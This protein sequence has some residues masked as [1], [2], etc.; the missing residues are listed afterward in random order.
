MLC[1]PRGQGEREVAQG[2]GGDGRNYGSGDA[3]GQ[4]V[5]DHGLAKVVVQI[6]G[7]YRGMGAQEQAGA[8]EQPAG[9]FRTGQ[10][11]AP[12]AADPGAHDVTLPQGVPFYPV[13][14]L[15]SDGDTAVGD[16]PV[17]LNALRSDHPDS[18]GSTV[19]GAVAAATWSATV[20]AW[21]CT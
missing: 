20:M 8:A 21:D 17:V 3:L 1:L 18:V 14:C 12:T 11:V 19:G 6:P 13:R 2:S 15:G 5:L 16:D 7:E 10:G 9:V 4:P